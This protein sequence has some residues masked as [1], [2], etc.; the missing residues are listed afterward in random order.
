[1][2]KINVGNML[3]KELVEQLIVAAAPLIA[4]TVLKGLQDDDAAAEG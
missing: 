4:E 3:S 2:D 1:M